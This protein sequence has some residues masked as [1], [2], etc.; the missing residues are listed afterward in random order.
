ML[1]EEARVLGPVLAFAFDA[2]SGEEFAADDEREEE[3]GQRQ[4]QDEYER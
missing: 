1:A 4:Q 2:F 3:P